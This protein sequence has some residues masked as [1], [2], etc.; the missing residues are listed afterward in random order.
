MSAPIYFVIKLSLVD[1]FWCF[2]C[3]NDCSAR[4]DRII[5]KWC[6]CL[7]IG[8]K[9]NKKIISAIWRQILMFKVSKQTYQS[10]WLIGS[11]A[12]G[13]TASLMAKNETK[14]LYQLFEDRFWCS[15]CLNDHIE[16]PNMIG[17]FASGT[18]TSLVAKNRT[19]NYLTPL[20]TDF[21]VQA[22]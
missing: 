13:A 16:V 5:C 3:L 14:K 21:D 6:Y 8:Q 12:S 10:A 2:R 20:K 9:C 4:H 18:N 22:V 1:R 15:R 11:F 17:S 7:P 19:K